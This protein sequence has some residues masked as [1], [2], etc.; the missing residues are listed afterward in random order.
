LR[1]RPRASAAALL[2]CG[3]SIAAA[4]GLWHEPRGE[5]GSKESDVV[6]A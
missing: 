3:K 4:D 6:F 1:L 5:T 2:R